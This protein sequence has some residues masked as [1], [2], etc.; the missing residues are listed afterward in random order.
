MQLSYLWSSLIVSSVKTKWKTYS[1]VSVKLYGIL[2]LP[3]AS[4]GH[5]LSSL[6]PRFSPVSLLASMSSIPSGIRMPKQ[7][8]I[9][10]LLVMFLFRSTIQSCN[11]NIVLQFLQRNVVLTLEGFH[12]QKN[13]SNDPHCTENE[14]FH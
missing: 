10:I 2:R 12:F 7:K 1:Q 4:L 13:Q 3:S 6:A 9:L 14:V 11:N 8:L 5:N